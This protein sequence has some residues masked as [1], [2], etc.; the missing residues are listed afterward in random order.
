M[1]GRDAQMG[2]PIH[3]ALVSAFNLLNDD[4]I[5]HVMSPI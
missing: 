2:E 3:H 5:D 1:G 4:G